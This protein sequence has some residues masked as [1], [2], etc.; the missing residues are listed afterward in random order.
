MSDIKKIV[1]AYSGGLDTSVLIK[2]LQDKYACDVVAY[3]SDVGQEPDV[4]PLKDRAEAANAKKL[5]IDDLKEEFADEYILPSLWAHAVYEGQYPMATALSRPLIV[6]H[7][8]QAAHKEGADAIAHG[9]T[10]KGNDQVRFEA[11]IQ[12]L[13]PDMKILAPI[14]DWDMKSREEEIL[15]AKKY[16]IPVDVSKKKPYS[17]DRNIW[18]ISIECGE[19]EDPWNEP[20]DDTYIMTCKPEDAPDEPEYVE[21]EFEKGV[22]VA[23]NGKKY[24][25]VEF[26]EKLNDIGGKHAIG[27]L[28]MVENRLVGIKSREIYECPAGDILMKAHKDLESLVL[29]RE[30]MH[31]KETIAVKYA[32]L[33]YNGLWFSPLKESLDAFIKQSQKYVTGVVRLKLYKGK[34]QV[35]GRK[36]EYSLYNEALATY[37][38]EDI[39]DQKL[40]KGF[41]DLWSLPLKVMAQNRNKK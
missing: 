22:P 1:L 23:I 38:E 14:R 32:E 33:V 8:V 17:I 4:K 34:A 6:K 30:L 16:N 21:V 10:G 26:I 36:S 20:S 13:D 15:Y 39:F 27:R 3:S 12:A 28:D 2:W 5:I 35:I 31:Y 40:A 24:K 25:L 19:L 41:I 37:T 29:D 9:C 18:G 11:G 7:L